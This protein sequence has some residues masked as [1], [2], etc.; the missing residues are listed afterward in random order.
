MR[1]YD[2]QFLD[3]ITNIPILSINSVNRDTTVNTGALQIEF[4]IPTA[5]YASPLTAGY[6]RIHGLPL[7]TVAAASK[8]NGSKVLVYAGM[9]KGLPLANP[10]TYGLIAQGTVLQAF[11]NWLGTEQT[12]EIQMMPFTGSSS[13]QINTSALPFVA[14]SSNTISIAL[15]KGMPLTDVTSA[16]LTAYFGSK[17]TIDMSGIHAPPLMLTENVSMYNKSLQEFAI[18]IRRYTQKMHL[19][20]DDGRVYSGYEIDASRGVIRVIDNE[21]PPLANVGNTIILKPEEFI[22]QPTWVNVISVQATIVLRSDIKLGDVIQFPKMPTLTN[23]SVMNQY[24]Q[25]S[26]FSTMFQVLGADASVRH[27][28]DFRSPSAQSWVT[29]INAVE[30]TQVNQRFNYNNLNV[31]NIA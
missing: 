20:T 29:V 22:G 28:G 25:S 27:V 8:L 21:L 15:N 10:S 14:G 13:R 19:V 24:R 3:A 23:A 1:R 16:V 2:V 12:L 30:L 9:H 6:L 18:W 17:F 7:P 31:G 4:D 5:T 26:V 11:G